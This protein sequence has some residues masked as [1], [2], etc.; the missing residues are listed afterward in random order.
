MLFERKVKAPFLNKPTSLSS[1]KEDE[2][3][4]FKASKWL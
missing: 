3:F 4:N 1:E 2:F